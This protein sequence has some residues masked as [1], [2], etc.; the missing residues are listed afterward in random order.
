MMLIVHTE[1]VDESRIKN[2]ASFRACAPDHAACVPHRFVETAMSAARVHVADSMLLQPR[3]SR[4]VTCQTAQNLARMRKKSGSDVGDRDRPRRRCKQLVKQATKMSVT[5]LSGLPPRATTSCA[6]TPRWKN[7]QLARSE[8]SSQ[9][10]AAAITCCRLPAR[11]PATVL[12][13]TVSKEF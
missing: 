3:D 4:R 1:T 5:K 10:S 9:A 8:L 7:V 11:A 13:M 6:A 2:S 12:A